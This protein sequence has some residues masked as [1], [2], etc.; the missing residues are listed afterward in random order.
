MRVDITIVA[1]YL[2]IRRK[3]MLAN[4]SL[5]TSMRE[6]SIQIASSLIIELLSLMIS[7]G[8]LKHF[9]RVAPRTLSLI[10]PSYDADRNKWNVH[11]RPRIVSRKM[12]RS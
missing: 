12:R 2:A 10:M 1:R 9:D 4:D 5:D 11:A 7:N 8:Y 6:K 3:L